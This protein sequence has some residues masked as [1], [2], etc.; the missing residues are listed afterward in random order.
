MNT[1]NPKKLL[2]SKWTAVQPKNKEKH[3]LVTELRFC[4]DD[5]QTV[6][7]CLLE[8]VY[9]KR[10]QA[11]DWQTLKNSSRWQQGWN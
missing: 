6:A 1:I 3:F 9:S 2:H 7:L 4:N 5:P 11:I 8:A 10:S